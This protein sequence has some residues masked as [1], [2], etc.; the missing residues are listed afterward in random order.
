MDTI[1]EFQDRLFTGSVSIQKMQG[2]IVP[3][4]FSQNQLLEYGKTDNYRT[5]SFCPTGISLSCLTDSPFIRV[6]Y[7]VWEKVRNWGFFDIYIND[8]FVDTVEMEPALR[9]VSELYYKLPVVGSKLKSVKIYFPH[10]AK[11]IILD[12]QFSEDVVVEFPAS[13]KS[14]LLCLGDSITQGM[15]AR[16]P[17]TTYPVLLSRSL[18]VDLLNQGVGGYVFNARSLDQELTYQPDIITVAYGTNDWGRYLSIEELRVRCAE[19]LEVLTR[20][21]P[22]AAIF[23]ITPFWREDAIKPQPM[24]SFDELSELITDLCQPYSSITVINGLELVPHLPTL[25][26]DGLHPT[27]QGFLH[28]AH[29]LAR[30]IRK[31]L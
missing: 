17:S 18:E 29:N 22:N 4:R 9:H 24:G 31:H 20:I 7:S 30:K 1:S 28:L 11:I 8:Q 10:I 2:G 27:D 26:T 6:T 5:R 19:Y 13:Q 14:N 12:I 25:F 15:D 3:V 16:H 21:Y 23:V